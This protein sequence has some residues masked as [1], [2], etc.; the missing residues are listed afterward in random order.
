MKKLKKPLDKQRNLWYIILMKT[1]KETY[2][3][4]SLKCDIA[5]T[6]KHIWYC[7]LIIA[8]CAGAS[9]ALGFVIVHQIYFV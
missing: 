4:A 6:Q 1:R 5:R 9:L 7:Q 2:K 8:A 3:I